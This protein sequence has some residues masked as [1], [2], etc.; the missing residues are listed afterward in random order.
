MVGPVF[1]TTGGVEA[2]GELTE[3]TR[4][5]PDALRALGGVFGQTARSVE[6][7]ATE[8]AECEFSEHMGARYGGHA[9]AYAAGILAVAESMGALT[10]SSRTFGRG[11]ESSANTLFEQDI[12]NGDAFNGVAPEPADG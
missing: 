3:Q 4:V 2:G 6:V 8:L 1:G 12:R 5:D 11:L 9:V 7:A 10:E